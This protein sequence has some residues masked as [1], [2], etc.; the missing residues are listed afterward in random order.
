MNMNLGLPELIVIVIIVVLPAVL[1]SQ[2]FH[3]AGYSRWLGLLLL[4]PLVNV[5]T[6]IWF[7]LNKWPLETEVERLRM[8]LAQVTQV[9]PSPRT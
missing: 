3:K 8:N 4:V 7:A 1:F 2:I 9:A 5:I 6:I